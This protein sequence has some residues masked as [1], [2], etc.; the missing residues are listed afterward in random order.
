MCELYKTFQKLC[1]YLFLKKLEFYP[2]MTER[3]LHSL[4][5]DELFDLLIQSTKELMNFNSE[6]NE[7]EYEDKR[8]EVQLIQR[9]IVSKRAEFPPR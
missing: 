3:N 1:K 7:I 4:C 2:Y 6:E 5:L 8:G 9:F